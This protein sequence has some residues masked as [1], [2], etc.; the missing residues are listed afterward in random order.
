[1][2]IVD[3]HCDSLSEVS[4][5]RGLANSYNFSKKHNF[6]QFVAHFSHTELGT[7][8]ERRHKLM[9][10]FDVYLAE[11]QRL[12][13]SRV[14]NGR[15][16][17]NVLENGKNGTLFSIEGGA[18]LFAESEEL[19]A[20]SRA[21]LAVYGLAWDNNELS[22]SAWDSIDTGL[23]EKGR[24]MVERATELGIILDV[25]HLSDKAFYETFE[26]SPMPHLATHSNF[27]D[28]CNSPR[29][30]TRDMAERIAM[31]GGV[32]GINIYPPFL[33]D[34]GKAD[35]NDILRHID[36]GLELLGDKYI[37]F[38][39]D[40]DGTDGLYPDGIN[41][42]ESI[43]DQVVDFLLSHYSASTVE[44]IAGRNIIDFLK[45]NLM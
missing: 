18:G 23:T 28:V 39:F 15:S 10:A 1:M 34:S 7:A 12:S 31:R 22:A 21:G 35:M 6:L 38:G 33:N 13:L 44:K 24:R 36:Y 16:L 42:E 17:F 40:I 14:E 29:N 11:C 26:F 9:H 19:L 8:E 41:T 3:M 32:I 30:L 37:G 27:R 5:S 20:L 45:N 4:E 2:Y 43:H 25:S